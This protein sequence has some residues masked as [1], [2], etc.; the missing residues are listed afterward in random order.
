MS[1]RIDKLAREIK[2]LQTSIDVLEILIFLK[3]G[4]VGK[5][6]NDPQIK[7]ELEHV[8]RGICPFCLNQ[9]DWQKLEN[10][11]AKYNKELGVVKKHLK[12]I[13]NNIGNGDD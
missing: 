1:E 5:S 13:I 8:E 7:V 3:K 2:R 4:Y 11:I 9:I 6:K 12:E 10:L